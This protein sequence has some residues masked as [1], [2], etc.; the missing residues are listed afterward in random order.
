MTRYLVI[1][2]FCLMVVFIILPAMVMWEKTV[3]TGQSLFISAFQ[4]KEPDREET[5]GAENT[6]T[7][8]EP[9]IQD[10]PLLKIYNKQENRI[11][12]M[13]LEKYLVGVVA[14]EMPSSFSFEALKAQA[15]AARTYTLEKYRATGGTGCN[16]GSVIADICTDST[17]CQAWTCTEDTEKY[18]KY[19]RAVYETCGEIITFNDVI[20]MA[21][22]HST[23]GGQ[24]EDAGALWA[25]P[26]HPYLRSIEC[27]YCRHS[28][29][30]RTENRVALKELAGLAGAGAAVP[31]ATGAHGHIS[32]KELTPGNRVSLLRLGDRTL[33]GPHIRAGL[34]LPSAAFTFKIQ[35]EEVIF[36]NRGFGHG[37][38][39]CQYGADGLAREGYTYDRIITLYYPGVSIRQDY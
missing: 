16:A 14:A 25:G 31:A 22:Y 37:V 9:D 12:E 15:V 7:A 10:G 5:S 35:H 29:Y 18:E 34:Q 39:L 11:M 6:S 24:T 28:P 38:G 23:C 26:G 27:G 30:F 8:G 1:L 36:S 17:H 13:N 32:I 21:C 20:I 3:L 4:Q 33:T 2:F 19:Y